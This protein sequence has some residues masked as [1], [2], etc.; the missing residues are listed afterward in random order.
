MLAVLRDYFRN[1]APSTPSAPIPVERRTLAD[2]RAPPASGLR[3]TW[4]GHATA[5]VEIDGRRF[6]L[7]PV[8][9]ERIS[10]VPG[11]GPKRFFEPPL[12]LEEVPPID[13]VLL[14][15]DHYDHLDR[16]TVGVLSMV[17]ARFIAPLGVGERLARWG[18]P[19]SQIRELDWWQTVNVG[20]VTITATPARHFSGRSAIMLD[21]NRTLW[22]G[23]ALTG[24]QHR[25]Y[26]SGDTAMFDGFDEIGETLGPFDAT[27]MEIGAYHHHWA[28]VHLGPEQ[29]IEAVR[30]VRGGVLIPLHWGTFDLAMHGWTEPIERL[31]VEASRTGTRVV[32][33]KPGQRVEPAALPAF[34]RWWPTL[35]WDTVQQHPI[36]SSGLS[37]VPINGAVT[38]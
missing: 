29:A 27:L 28:D 4:L 9:A 7:D 12:A 2:F 18:V 1:K 30:R 16:R 11:F 31:L 35:P 25:V 17:G 8:W 10:P 26:Y 32:A 37:S 24:P 38:R 23:Y 34:E 15:H 33:L 19:R 20:G 21:R 3:V 22:A 13:A 14:S 5:I 36:V 6:L